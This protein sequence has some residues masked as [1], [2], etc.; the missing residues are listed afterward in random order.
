MKPQP[1]FSV[2]VKGWL[3][4]VMYIKVPFSWIH[5]IL[6]VLVWRPCGTLAKEQGSPELISDY[7]AQRAH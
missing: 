6:R 3:H 7:E 2:G 1:T 4:S 5:R